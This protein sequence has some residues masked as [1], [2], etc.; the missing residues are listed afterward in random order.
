MPVKDNSV[1][2][3][4]C[5]CVSVCSGLLLCGNDAPS[6]CLPGPISSPFKGAG[7][8]RGKGGLM[9]DFLGG[10]YTK[11]HPESGS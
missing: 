2:I 3:C 5:M 4:V 9:G 10:V 1:R 7:G 11:S 6:A 8:W